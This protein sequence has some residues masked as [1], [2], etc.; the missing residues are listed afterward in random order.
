MHP[1]IAIL[2]FAS[3]AVGIEAGDAM[4]KRAPLGL[5][6]SG[7]VQPGKYLILVAGDVAS[8]DEALAAGQEIG[9]DAIVDRV[10]LPDVHP[11][12]VTAMQGDRSFGEG[13]ALGVIETATVAAVIEAADAAVKGA[14]VTAAQIEMADGLGGKGYVLFGGVLSEVQAAVDAGVGA[15]TPAQLVAS[16]VISQLHDEMR[17][18][19]VASP[20]FWE[21]VHGGSP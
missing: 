9:G 13:E 12:V 6:Q 16:V 18:D 19:V 7:T 11:D 1:A 4:V 10:F 17:D 21:R 8:V 20:F 14:T 2:E 15:L 3:I 5:I